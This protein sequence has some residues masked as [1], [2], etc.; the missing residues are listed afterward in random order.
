MSRTTI[1]AYYLEKLNKEELK[2]FQHRLLNQVALPEASSTEVASNL[3][4]QYGSRRAWDLALHTWKQMGKKQLCSQ[5][6]QE[7]GLTPSEY[8]KNPNPS[9][10][11]TL[12]PPLALLSKEISDSIRGWN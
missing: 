11:V 8:T 9:L 5:A 2:E 12:S 4:A 1:L 6:Q 7:K 10:T 3:V